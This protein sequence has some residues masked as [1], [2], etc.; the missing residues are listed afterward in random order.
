MRVAASLLIGIAVIFG[1]RLVIEG[2]EASI[3]K[4]RRT[5]VQSLHGV[6]L[7][8]GSPLIATADTV[9]GIAKDQRHV[10]TRPADLSA[11]WRV[12]DVDLPFDRVSGLTVSG[13]NLFVTDSSD[14]AVYQV[15]LATRRRSTV[16][17]EGR[18]K[19]PG[20][21][22]VARDVFVADDATGKLY[23][24]R[25][26]RIREI[27][28]DT[29]IGKA[30]PL[31]LAASGDDLLVSSPDGLILELRGLGRSDPDKELSPKQSVQY[32][33]SLKSTMEPILFAVQK[34]A[35]PEI[36]E[37][38][39]VTIWKGVVYVIDRGHRSVFAFS[40][41]DQ[42]PR[43]IRL[44]H[45]GRIPGASPNSMAVN[46]RALYVL[47][48]DELER[49]PRLIPAEVHLR[50][51]SR[52]EAMARVYGYLQERNILPVR[53]VTLEENIEYTLKKYRVI[54]GAYPSELTRI[55]CRL[56]VGLCSKGQSIRILRPEAKLWVPDLYSENYVDAEPVRLDGKESLG[57]RADRRI[58]SKE[59]EGWKSEGQ[60]RE[61]NQS[62]L[63]KSHETSARDVRTGEYMAP[64]EY[65]R[66]LVP[67]V[68]GDASR[69]GALKR[70]ERIFEG[71]RVVSL[72]E[73]PPSANAADV[74][75]SAKEADLKSLKAEFDAMLE[76]VDYFAPS[77]SLVTA[78]VGIAEKFIDQAH[79][80]FLNAWIA[81]DGMVQPTPAGGASPAAVEY[82]IRSFEDTDHGTMVAGLIGARTT[83]FQHPG[84]APHALLLLLQSTDPPIGDDIRKAVLRGVRLFNISAHYNINVIPPSLHE[85]IKKYPAALF[86]VAAGNDARL[87]VDEEVCGAF[88]VFP[89]CWYD[90]PNVLVVTATNAAGDLVLPPNGSLKGANWGRKAVHL[91]AP[92]EGYHA[93]AVG[94]SYAPVRGSSFAA[95][96]V[97]ATAAL[98]FSQRVTE[99]AA[100]KERLISTADPQPGL[101]GKLF[102]GRL[103]IR[104]ALSSLD[105]GVLSRQV[106]NDDNTVRTE[107]ERIT[108]DAG[109][110]TIRDAA[111]A[112][113]T[114]PV[115]KLR[116]VHKYGSGYRIIYVDD[117]NA[118]Q[119]PVEGASFQTDKAAQFGA[120]NENGDPIVVNLTEWADFVAPIPWS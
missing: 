30:R 54:P 6:P 16:F 113:R 20:S 41:Y 42:D 88:S 44:A 104:R 110:I 90:K 92:G 80:D 99:P 105:F 18:L 29:D 108:I 114:I 24:I 83:G 43:P 37:P 117:Q 78:K 106:R 27:A 40:R 39:Q 74:E 45:N 70:L 72:E 10:V 52:S 94:S 22:A 102:G 96:L 112:D 115:R 14:K 59:F 49:W 33:T 79:P 81:P 63:E 36:R 8:K 65:V 103:N 12:L 66:Y 107:T 67:A 101:A 98:L 58:N 84:L 82:R 13:N 111:G 120:T 64:V 1:S 2:G 32:S 4:A 60:L 119:P 118:L 51:T 85:A 3:D 31:S 5:S 87:G 19:E 73:K 93:P 75:R 68:A 50:L 116:R 25:D 97:T 57:E 71:L 46:D 56:N 21:V 62:E 17:E 28:L 47:H 23:R 77:P 61:L 53:Q 7:L 15:D 11:P 86:I 95:P 89:A 9:F 48:G 69:D 55:L 38:A 100:I 35:F 76:K 109:Q 91:A 34:R 26:G